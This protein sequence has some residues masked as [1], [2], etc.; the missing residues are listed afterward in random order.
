M[1]DSPFELRVFANRDGDYGVVLLQKPQRDRDANGKVNGWRMVVKVHGAPL[2]AV[3][4]QACQEEVRR[5]MALLEDEAGFAQTLE[6]ASK[7][8]ALYCL[9]GKENPV[10]ELR[11]YSL[12]AMPYGYSG[13]L[14]V[15][16]P[17]RMDYS[18]A[19]SATQYIGSRLKAILQS[20]V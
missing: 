3:L 17:T 16:G 2:K 11:D 15:L 7:A 6:S 9:I 19:F 4:D 1:A 8:E 5:L 20:K 14:G 13:V 18:K 10:R 12:V